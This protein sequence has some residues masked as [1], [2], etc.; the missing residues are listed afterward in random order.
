MNYRHLSATGFLTLALL[1]QPPP[2]P[3]SPVFGNATAAPSPP[4]NLLTSSPVR[5]ALPQGDGSRLVDF[6]IALASID[7]P[8]IREVSRFSSLVDVPWH[9]PEL[10]NLVR[11]AESYGMKTLLAVHDLFFTQP[12]PSVRAW[13]LRPDHAERWR[14]FVKAHRGILSYDHLWAVYLVDEPFWNDVSVDDLAAAHRAVKESL[15]L[16][17]TMTSL[18]RHDLEAAPGDLPEDLFDVVGFHA[19]AV[20]VD[21][22][23]DPQYQHSLGLLLDKL[24]ERDYV[25]V[26][27]AWWTETRHGAAGLAPEDL[28]ERAE[29][30]RRVAEDIDAIALAAFIWQTLPEG[31]GLRDLPESVVRE[32]LRVGA[33][34]SGR[35]GVP[36]S[37]PALAGETVLSFHDCRFHAAVYWR[38]PGTGDEGQGVA[39]QLSRDT[40]I[41]WFFEE[42]NIELTVKLLDGRAL[43]GHWWV[44]WSHM[45]DLEVWLE[46]TDTVTGSVVRY[47]E[48]RSDTL[49]FPGE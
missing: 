22:N 9:H 31:T 8:T 41:F 29:Q 28:A 10:E 17:P 15:P 44:F 43:N 13:V 2:S 24:P 30:Y 47:T 35:C 25:V 23:L 12:D 37:V 26:A 5:V 4:E 3:A 45:T 27:D 46:I 39:V 49:A 20:P 6:G 40:G 18:N 19:Y 36:E 48:P 21:P 14:S 16:V 11:Y 32:Y 38:N 1:L 33:D 34:V 42:S 7:R